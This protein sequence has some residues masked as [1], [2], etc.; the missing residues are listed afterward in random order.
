MFAA[1]SNRHRLQYSPDMHWKMAPDKHDFTVCSELNTKTKDDLV[2]T[3]SELTNLTEDTRRLK[4]AATMRLKSATDQSVKLLPDNS[5]L[6]IDSK[7]W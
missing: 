7:L 3:A 4:A 6:P 2:A 1:D 5:V